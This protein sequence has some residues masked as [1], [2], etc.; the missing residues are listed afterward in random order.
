MPCLLVKGTSK[1]N[2][3]SSTQYKLSSKPLTPVFSAMTFPLVYG[4]VEER[5]QPVTRVTQTAQNYQL[6]FPFGHRDFLWWLLLLFL[7]FGFLRLFGTDLLWILRLLNYWPFLKSSEYQGWAVSCA[8]T[9]V[10]T[11]IETWK[12]LKHIWKKLCGLLL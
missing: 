9:L 7:E 2:D 11:N 6:I 1:G 12:I 3:I 4:D 5:Y 10:I 8:R